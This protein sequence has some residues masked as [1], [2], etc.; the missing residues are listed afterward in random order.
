MFHWEGPAPTMSAAATVEDEVTATSQQTVYQYRP[1]CIP[2]HFSVLAF[3]L[4]GMIFQK[5][6][7]YKLW[8]N[9]DCDS[10][11][12]KI[13]VKDRI[14]YANVR[15]WNS[16]QGCLCFWRRN[17]CRTWWARAV[18]CGTWI[19]SAYVVAGCRTMRH[20]SRYIP[21]REQTAPRWS[22]RKP[23]EKLLPVDATPCEYGSTSTLSKW[24]PHI[25]DL[26]GAT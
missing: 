4:N 9:R 19:V 5:S 12:L 26:H 25:F 20:R 10:I 3:H 23:L 21:R 15:T 13:K 18:R 22:T 6:L 8:V 7:I 1:I 17:C 2:L 14:P 11:N 16:T 24:P